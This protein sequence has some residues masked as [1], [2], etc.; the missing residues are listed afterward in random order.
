MKKTINLRK[1]EIMSASLVHK[2]AFEFFE[3]T[4]KIN[5]DAGIENFLIKIPK[6]HNGSYYIAM[7]KSE[8]ND[9]KF[10]ELYVLEDKKY[11]PFSVKR[12][13]NVWK[14]H[15]HLEEYETMQS[16]EGVTQYLIPVAELLTTSSF[17]DESLDDEDDFDF[18]KEEVSMKDELNGQQNLFTKPEVKKKVLKAGPESPSKD[19]YLMHLTARDLFSIIHAKPVSNKKW[20]NDLVTQNT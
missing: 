20:I 2:K 3:K 4:L 1:N 6:Y 15:K 17:V 9:D 18:G 5:H 7:M 13:L 10:I 12:E 19:V 11:K 16:E 8:L 14:F